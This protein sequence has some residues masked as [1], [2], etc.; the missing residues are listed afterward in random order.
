MA[1]PVSISVDTVGTGAVPEDAIVEAIREV[2]DLTPG[3]IIEALDLRKAIYSPTASYGHFGR[4]PCT[5]GSGKNGR[6][7]FTWE[8]TDRAAALQRAAH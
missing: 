7:F 8:R 6:T 1:E 2:F 4:E 3:G 5:N